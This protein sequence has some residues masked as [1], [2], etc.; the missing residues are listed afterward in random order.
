MFAC[1]APHPSHSHFQGEK[2]V[3]TAAD[4]AAFPDG[5]LVGP[6]EPRALSVSVASASRAGRGPQPT[7]DDEEEADDAVNTAS[8]QVGIWWSSMLFWEGRGSPYKFR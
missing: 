1:L 6:E 2:R 3:Y 8:L 7:D 4:I 5:V